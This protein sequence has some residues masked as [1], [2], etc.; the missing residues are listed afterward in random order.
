MTRRVGGPHKVFCTSRLP[1]AQSVLPSPVENNRSERPDW[2]LTG[3]LRGSGCHDT[4]PQFLP[5]L[6]A[7]EAGLGSGAEAS[8]TPR[9]P[10]RSAPASWLAALLWEPGSWQ[11]ASSSWPA[12]L[13]ASAFL[14]SR[15]ARVE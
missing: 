2:L 10:G 13:H 15:A 7:S 6:A 11:G 14:T 9:V 1:C 12:L 8:R 5:V 4:A 3:K